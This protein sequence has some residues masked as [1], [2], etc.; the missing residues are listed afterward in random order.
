[1]SKTWGP[2]TGNQLTI[3]LVAAIAAFVPGT[4]MAVDAYTRVAIQDPISGVKSTV[5]AGRRLLV[6]DPIQNNMGNNPVTFVRKFFSTGSP[7]ANVYVVP[8]GKALI[9]Q[10]FS[11][12]IYP[13]GVDPDGGTAL[14][15]AQANCAGEIIA[16]AISD[17]SGE[18]VNQT[19]GSGIAVPA[20]RTV[21]AFG[22]QNSGTASF[23]GFLVPA[24]WVPPTANSTGAPAA[25]TTA[26]ANSLK[27]AP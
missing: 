17:R 19:F 7:C 20:G 4:L 10:S 27:A 14:L 24:S 8:A 26:G 16:G 11:A 3:L 1:M 6:F 2:F 5:D 21:S 25:T 12:Y 18:S 15:Y 22:Y 9:I 23:Y 13:T